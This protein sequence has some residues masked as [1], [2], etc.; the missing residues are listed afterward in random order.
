MMA[1][2]CACG[3]KMYPDAALLRCP[4]CGR[5][6]ATMGPCSMTSK[7]EGREVEAREGGTLRGDGSGAI[8]IKAEAGA[9]HVDR[10]H[11]ATL[12]NGV[13]VEL[14]AGT[15]LREAPT[16]IQ[17]ASAEEERA[18]L[19]RATRVKVRSRAGA[20][21]VVTIEDDAGRTIRLAHVGAAEAMR[22]G[23]P[24]EIETKT[25]GEQIHDEHDRKTHADG[26]CCVCDPAPTVLADLTE[27]V[28]LPRE[29]APSVT[30][31]DPNDS[32][33]A[34]R[35]TET[36]RVNAIQRAEIERLRE[37]LENSATPADRAV[38]AAMLGSLR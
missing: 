34:A 30:A 2:E 8:T 3:R 28:G 15:V 12:P 1:L 20:P 5:P 22:Y 14:P 37:Q 23:E 16:P 17:L 10:P 32:S 24:P 7:P 29:M 36:M 27:R 11:V 38:G 33:W 31:Y 4:G 19:P 18:I 35:Y 6:T 21:T 9:V 26:S 25:L 13:R